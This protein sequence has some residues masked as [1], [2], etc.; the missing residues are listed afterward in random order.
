MLAT[1]L[2]ALAAA[3]TV[4]AAPAARPANARGPDRVICRGVTRT[5]TRVEQRVCLT[6]REWEIVEEH[7][8]ELIREVQRKPILGR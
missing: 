4:D 7:A 3:Q 8:M 1:V 2:L 5:G 6:A